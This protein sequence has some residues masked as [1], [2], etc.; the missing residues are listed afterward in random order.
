MKAPPPPPAAAAVEVEL[1]KVTHYLFLSL[2]LSD[3]LPTSILKISSQNDMNIE[4]NSK[5]SYICFLQMCAGG[6]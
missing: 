3:P 5:K 1:R 4:K 2:S 6:T